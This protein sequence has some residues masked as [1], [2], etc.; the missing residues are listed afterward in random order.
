MDHQEIVVGLDESKSAR[1]AL[2]WAAS[3]AERTG[4]GVASGACSQL[5]ARSHRPGAEPEFV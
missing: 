4:Y 1:Q 2:R 5:A 3:Y